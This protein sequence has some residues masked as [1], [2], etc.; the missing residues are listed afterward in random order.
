M[1]RETPLSFFLNDSI[2]RPAPV[3]YECARA[4][5]SRKPDMP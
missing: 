2:S 1:W 3:C 5:K 4:V